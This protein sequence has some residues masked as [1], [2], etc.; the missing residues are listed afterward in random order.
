MNVPFRKIKSSEQAFELEN[1]GITCKTLLQYRSGGL[2]HAQ[3]E[4]RGS[5]EL[6]CDICAEPF[7][8][9]INE[10]VEILLS[11]GVY[12]GSDENLDVVEVTSSIISIDELL[13]AE[14]ELIRCD[15]NRCDACQN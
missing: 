9:P 4:L 6:D 5:L 10:S 2:I 13:A 15:Y 8:K 1:S 3:M 7:I 12:N 11:D 14:I